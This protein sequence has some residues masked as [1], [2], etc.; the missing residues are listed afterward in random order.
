[1]FALMHYAVDAL[2]L[3]GL[4]QA[5]NDEEIPFGTAFF[6]SIGAAIGTM[7][8][9]AFGAAALMWAVHR[10]AI[11]GVRLRA[12]EAVERLLAIFGD[13]HFDLLLG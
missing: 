13:L 5:V 3:M 11:E 7:S 12:P 9:H 2:I 4:L 10:G 1:M 6:T 8:A